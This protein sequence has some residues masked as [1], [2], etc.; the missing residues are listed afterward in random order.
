VGQQVRNA[1]SRVPADGGVVLDLRGDP[2]GLLGEAVAVA[3]AFLADGPVVSFEQ[4]D[5]PTTRFGVVEAGNATVPLVVL[6]DGGTA[7]AAEVV[8]GAL[9][10]RDRAVI[11]GARTFGKGSVQE[12]SVLSDGSAIELTVGHYLTPDGR[13]IDGVGIEP[14]VLVD[15]AAG[16]AAAEQRALTVLAG[17]RASVGT[18]GQG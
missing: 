18:T 10:D 14:D 13:S 9:Q 8:A 3:S 15:P 2:G 5:R 1:V 17:L 7:S 4:R 11:V 16:A 12:P 6:V